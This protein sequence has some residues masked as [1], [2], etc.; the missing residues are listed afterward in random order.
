MTIVEHTLQTMAGMQ[1]VE[2]AILEQLRARGAQPRFEWNYGRSLAELPRH[3]VHM[4]VAVGASHLDVDWPSEHIRD[5]A[6]HIERPDVRMEIR[7]I[8]EHLTAPKAA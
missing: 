3:A 8:V 1:N 6:N 7:R 4:E 2:R 5:S